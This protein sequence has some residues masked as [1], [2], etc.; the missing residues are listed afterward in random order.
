MVLDCI[1]MNRSPLR[2]R[3]QIRSVSAVPS[4][5][6]I[7][8]ETHEVK[9]GTGAQGTAPS[10]AEVTGTSTNSCTKTAEHH[11]P[12]QPHKPT[13]GHSVASGR[14]AD[15]CTGNAGSKAA[16]SKTE[17][18][19]GNKRKKSSEVKAQKPSGGAV[20]KLKRTVAESGKANAAFEAEM[21]SATDEVGAEAG[22]AVR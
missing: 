10:T 1:L 6:P 9:G 13:C 22:P 20:G 18:A 14:A 4:V 2:K 3:F 12:A 16:A 8:R 5:K 15:H 7:A 21:K 11:V 17:K 19:S